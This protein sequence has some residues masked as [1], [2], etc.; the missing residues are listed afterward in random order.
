MSIDRKKIDNFW[1]RRTQCEDPRIATHF[2]LDDTI[3]FDVA[4]IK[5]YLP[6]QGRLLDLGC[7]TGVI[8]N[9]FARDCSYIRAVDKYDVFLKHC[10]CLPHISTQQADITTYKDDQTYDVIIIFGV[11]NYI[12]EQ[13]IIHIYENCL[14]MLHPQGHLIV[15]H[16]SGQYEDVIVDKYSEDIKDWYHAIYRFHEKDRQLMEKIFKKVSVLDIYPPRLNRWENTH[17]YAYV[18]SN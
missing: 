18:G 1:E 6:P 17:F 16:G 7:G 9:Y 14:S 4:L 2:K 3:D 15:K 13:E 10:I 5:K 8:T 11:L 12:E